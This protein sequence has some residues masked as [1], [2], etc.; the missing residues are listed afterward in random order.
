ME[1]LRLNQNI[2]KL[3]KE[4]VARRC[5]CCDGVNILKSPAV[6]MPFVSDRALG[7]APVEIDDSWG[8]ST[9]PNGFAYSIC[10][11][12]ACSD[13]GFL[14]LDIR[15]SDAEMTSLYRN[16]RGDEY[17]ELREQYEPG[18][19]ERNRALNV[20]VT[21]IEAV[22]DFLRPHLDTSIRILDWGG[23]T[24]IN[25]PFARE[26]SQLHIY[27][28]SNKPVIEGASVVDLNTARQNDYSLI[29]C[30]QVL[31]HVPYPDELLLE[32]S[33]VMS[34]D[35]VL[36]IELPVEKLILEGGEVQSLVSKKRHWHEHI[37]FYTENSLKQLLD[38]CDMTI[39]ELK[40]TKVQHHSSEIF[41]YQIACKLKP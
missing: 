11:T 4:R 40:I 27:D 29:V 22:E 12:L 35:S 38:R 16:Y 1:S 31:E 15:F 3:Q 32:V 24:G 10:N 14:F 6:L 39:L 7:Y 18:Y 36:Y 23:D 19:R 2:N 21:F 41:I 30:S 34:A 9:I 13:C 25:S 8:L 28:I 5:I 20:G 26:R 33:S 37:N 17:T